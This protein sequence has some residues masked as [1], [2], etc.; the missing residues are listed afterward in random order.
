MKKNRFDC[1]GS[2]RIKTRDVEGMEQYKCIVVPVF[3]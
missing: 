3:N 1:Y 2:T